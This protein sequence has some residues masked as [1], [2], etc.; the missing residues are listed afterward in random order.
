M[1]F[2]V[3]DIVARIV[4]DASDFNKGIKEASK[5]A[6]SFTDTTKGATKQVDLLGLAL[7]SV[8]AIKIFDFLKES[9]KEASNFERSMVT[10]DI[11]AERFGVS[12][13]EAKKQ[14]ELLGKELRIGVGASAESLQNL[15]KSGLSL[16]QASDLLRRFTNEAITGKS[17]NISLAQAVQNLS[18]A[19][20]TQNSALGNLS[21]IN[22][23]FENIIAR[24]SGLIENYNGKINVQAGYTKELV[25]QIEEY[26]KQLKAKG[27]TLS[28]SSE[29]QSKYV[30]MLELTNLTMGSSERFVGTFIDR[31]AELDQKIL[32]LQ[33]GFGKLINPI[34]NELLAI[35]LKII[36]TFEELSK[37][38]S[39]NTDVVVGISSAL[40]TLLIPGLIASTIAMWNFAVAVI[41]ATWPILLIAVIIGTLAYFIYRIW[42]ENW[43][44]IQEI[45]KSVIDWLVNAFNGLVNAFNSSIQWIGNTWNWLKDSFNAG[46]TAISNAFISFKDGVIS[47]LQPVAD[48]FVWLMNTIGWWWDNFLYPILYFIF[49]V[50]ARIFYEIGQLIYRAGVWIYENAIKPAFTSVYNFI[51]DILT[52]LKNFISTNFD[53]LVQLTIKWG[54]KFY[55]LL[56][57][58]IVKFWNDAMWQLDQ[59]KLNI[60]NWFSGLITSVGE[61]GV[62]LLEK[63]MEPW[64]KAKKFI[65]ETAQKIKDE[66]DKINPFHKESP[67]LVENVQNGVQ[68]IITSYQRLNNLSFTPAVTQFEDIPASS[69]NSVIQNVTVYPSDSL[70][71]ST[72]ADRL[73]YKYRN[74][75]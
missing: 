69:T 57:A 73:A 16:E 61:W 49:A 21:G 56:I 27:E 12:A 35:L 65:E 18:F 72:I 52:R 14:A 37:W 47:A 17:A 22:E 7:K 42:T 43:W 53:A 33:V 25:A 74:A 41:S 45:T 58:P 39:E 34:L 20:T 59:L 66:A 30:G 75:L 71:V 70:D 23:N 50:F 29:A 3:G 64:N 54:A 32:D 46:V 40:V 48:M 62:K 5:Q 4:T 67:S 55:E 13:E 63:L 68:D 38:V 2:K 10:L 11:I 36:P 31:Q 51:S 1:A 24:G 8:V 15:L 19:Y 9:S 26:K 28:A 60:S 44:G 6:K